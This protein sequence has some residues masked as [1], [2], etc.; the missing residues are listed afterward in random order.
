[1]VGVVMGSISD[2][3]VMKDACNVLEE[4]GIPYEKKIVSA[5]RTP[6]DPS[7][8]PGLSALIALNNNTLPEFVQHNIFFPG[9]RKS[10]AERQNNQAACSFC[11]WPRQTEA[12]SPDFPSAQ[13]L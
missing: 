6:E 7:A 4:F 1:M 11:S 2:Y 10:P 3:E 13:S 8:P 9:A 5:H 12:C